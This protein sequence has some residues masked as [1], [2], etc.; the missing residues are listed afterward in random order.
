MA[1]LENTNIDFYEKRLS[2]LKSQFIGKVICGHANGDVF[3]YHCINSCELQLHSRS[4]IKD[5]FLYKVIDLYH[6]KNK[7]YNLVVEIVKELPTYNIEVLEN[8]KLQVWWNCNVVPP[9]EYMSRD[10][11][12]SCIKY[13]TIDEFCDSVFY[14]ISYVEIIEKSRKQREFY[15][16]QELEKEVKK[17][18]LICKLDNQDL[19]CELDN[20]VKSVLHL[21][22][23]FEKVDYTVEVSRIDL[24][25][26]VT[27]EIS[28]TRFEMQESLKEFQR[29]VQLFSC[30]FDR[31]QINYKDKDVKKCH[32][33]DVENLLG[34]VVENAINH[35]HFGYLKAVIISKGSFEKSLPYFDNFLKCQKIN[36]IASSLRKPNN[37]YANCKKIAKL[38]VNK[39]FDLAK[40]V[41][42]KAQIDI[43]Q[44]V[45]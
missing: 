35:K 27:L 19:I 42:A 33:F 26:F 36:N 43:S 25:S 24:S 23:P 28:E 21:I 8:G 10:K 7:R 4:I 34:F 16:K 6:V 5:C 39:N 38:I 12:V 32:P 29:N 30:V 18:N 14:D 9:K 31:F 17:K 45:S 3:D 41:A 37:A 15:L 13:L 40:K 11:Y 44:W 2:E 1:S 22:P 20:Q